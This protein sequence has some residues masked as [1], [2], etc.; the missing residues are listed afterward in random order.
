MAE[1]SLSAGS[2]R[3]EMIGMLAMRVFLLEVET[4][5]KLTFFGEAG[6]RVA[7]DNKGALHTFE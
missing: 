7:Y 5:Y 2:Y 1:W 3:G 4:F 6:N